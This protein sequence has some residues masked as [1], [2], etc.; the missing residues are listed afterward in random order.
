MRT[1]PR[2]SPDPALPE[3]TGAQLH[4]IERL[5]AECDVLIDQIRG[6]YTGLVRDTESAES[7]VS[8]ARAER[9]EH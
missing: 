8:A 9:Q 2:R 1:E 4:R 3:R 5:Q 6:I 7:A